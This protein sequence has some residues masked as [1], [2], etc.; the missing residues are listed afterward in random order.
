[1]RDTITTHGTKNSSSAHHI[2]HPHHQ[3]KSQEKQRVDLLE[4]IAMSPLIQSNTRDGVPERPALLYVVTTT[5]LEHGVLARPAEI[6]VDALVRAAEAV[7]LFESVGG[8]I[9]NFDDFKVAL[10]VRLDGGGEAEG[11]EE[12][13]VNFMQRG[14]RRD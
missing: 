12:G 1:M 6:V 10:R 3:T 5:Q 4:D 7:A 14:A 8:D 13:R 2:P 11:R 9:V